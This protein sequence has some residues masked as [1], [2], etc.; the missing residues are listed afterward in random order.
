VHEHIPPFGLD[1]AVLF[2]GL[3]PQDGPALARR[4]RAVAPVA[5]W[6]RRGRRLGEAPRPQLGS[7]R[8]QRVG[9][10]RSRFDGRRFDGRRRS[11]LILLPEGAFGLLV[12]ACVERQRRDTAAGLSRDV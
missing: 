12:V 1:E 2:A 9:P 8:E 10:R 4:R 5:P 3:E 11:F 7:F 6:T